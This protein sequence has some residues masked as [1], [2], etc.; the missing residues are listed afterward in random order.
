MKHTQ[1][2]LVRHGET[3]W[4]AEKRM[5][6][7]LNSDLTNQGIKQAQ[8]LGEKFASLPID[9]CYTSDSPR[10]SKTADLVTQY[11]PLI[12]QTDNRLREIGMGTWEG[13][14]REEIA[15]TDSLEW[16]R[17]WED[18]QLFQ[19]HNGGETFQTLRNRSS[20]SID[21]IVAKHPNQKIL[22]FSHRLTIK[23]IINNLLQRD[24]ADL[25]SLDDVEPN[26]LSILE[27]K[28][29]QAKVIAYSD[30]THYR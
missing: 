26:S 29:D 18:P 16:H 4:N 12:P 6:G 21:E 28:N 3:I 24:L 5:Q 11:L 8:L 23:T 22:I 30:T 7:H 10:A 20:A 2:Y 27:L 1:L 9:I 19:G 14:T 13:R 25:T 17:F 15:I